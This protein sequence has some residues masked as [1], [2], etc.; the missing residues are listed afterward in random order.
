MCGRQIMIV[1]TR[2][3]FT[4][5]LLQKYRFDNTLQKHQHKHNTWQSQKQTNSTSVAEYFY[6]AFNKS[7]WICYSVA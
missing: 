3:D 2:V 6:C 7:Q 1:T 4:H 5:V